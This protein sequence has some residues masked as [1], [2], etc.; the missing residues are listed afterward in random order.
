M[1]D[2]VDQKRYERDIMRNRI[3]ALVL[4]VVV[5]LIAAA[6]ILAYVYLV[7]YPGF[8][9]NSQWRIVSFV[10]GCGT[11]QMTTPEPTCDS[12]HGAL[13]VGDQ[14]LAIRT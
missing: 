12:G 11:F 13:R 10:P 7:P 9:Y 3:L 6:Y 8:D 2:N 14:I 4:A 5:L 1:R